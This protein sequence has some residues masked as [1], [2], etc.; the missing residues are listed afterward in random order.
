M[1]RQRKRRNSTAHSTIQTNEKRPYNIK[2]RFIDSIEEEWHGADHVDAKHKTHS[3]PQDIPDAD[4]Q[5]CHHDSAPRVP[6]DKAGTNK[7]AHWQRRR[8]AAANTTS[9]SRSAPVLHNLSPN[10]L[11]PGSPKNA[12]LERVNT[13]ELSAM[14]ET[15][16]WQEF[17]KYQAMFAKCDEVVI[18]ALGSI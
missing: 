17:C 18:L 15:L 11:P 8:A 5:T 9:R 6:A 12:N 3:L 1:P 4:I 2:T 13:T 10:I 14:E 16:L 7:N